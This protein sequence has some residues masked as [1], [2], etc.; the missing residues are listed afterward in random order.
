MLAEQFINIHRATWERQSALLKTASS[1]GLSALSAEE[2]YEIGRLYRT[3]T[4][5][6]AIAQRDFADHR[7]VDYLNSLVA[8]SHSVIYHTRATTG[9][10]FLRFFT[11][12]FPQAFRST[13]RYSLAAAL[14]MFLPAIVAFFFTWND[15]AAGTVLLPGSEGLIDDIRNE[16]EWWL[17]INQEGRSASASFIMTNNIR[18]ALMAFAG[19]IALGIFSLWVLVQNGLMLGVVSG[20]AQAYG[21]SE[22]LWGF[23]AAHGMI[24]LSVIFIAGGAGLQLGWSVLR[25]GLLTRRA[26]LAIAARRAII[27][28]IGCVP[29]LVIAGTIEGFIS[30]SSLPS[31]FKYAVSLL[32]GVLLYAYLLLV[33]RE[34]SQ[35]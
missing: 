22:K 9:Q 29:L 6:L 17:R 23:I 14:M 13:W 31:L 35:Q 12:S 7:V 10:Q 30:P 27:I 32:S 1:K 3:I 34:Q 26:A 21:F 20:A 25:P 16:R 8:Q 11:H 5:D 19:G 18:V 4:S 24:E 28:L 2:L 33:G 15:P